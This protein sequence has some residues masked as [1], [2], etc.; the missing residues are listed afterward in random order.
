MIAERRR[1][2]LASGVKREGSSPPSPVFER[3]PRRFIAIASVSCASREIEPRL[4]APVQKRLH[5]LARRLD[6]LERRSAVARRSPRPIFSSP[7]SVALRAASSLIGCA[8]SRYFANAAL[9]R[10]VSSALR[11]ARQ[12]RGDVAVGRAHRV[13]DERDRLGVPHVVLAVAP[14]RVDAADRQQLVVRHRVGAR[15]ALE[16]LGREHVD[17]RRRR[18]ARRCR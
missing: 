14:P 8:Y 6:L 17:A 4:I 12:R 15:V 10:T 16:R 2:P 3:P 18:S 9:S 11:V 5:D 7:R 1:S 13:L